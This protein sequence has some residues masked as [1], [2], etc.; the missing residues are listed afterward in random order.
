VPLVTVSRQ[1]GSGGSAV[2]A[3]VAERLGWRLLDNTIVDAIA[4]QMGVSPDTVR[5]LDER[6][7]P[8]LTRLADTLALSESEVL[9]T[10]AGAAV[11][12]ADDRIIESTRLV[13]E[14]AV[15]QGPVVVVGRGAQVVLGQH[16]D[17]IHVFCYAPR[18]AL[19]RRIATREA[20]PIAT[21][22]HRVDDVNHQRAI[23]VHRHYG[24]SWGAPETYHL[25]LNTEWLGIEG[26]AAVIVTAAEEKFGRAETRDQ[27]PVVRN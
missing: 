1:F 25:C 27:G 22:L 11:L 2:A 4:Q 26:A 13:M 7:P 6:Q 17:A 18:E 5:A 20:I 14:A 9:S 8:L 15:A 24:R 10:A 19:A 23:A 12:S 16:T 3:L 21:A